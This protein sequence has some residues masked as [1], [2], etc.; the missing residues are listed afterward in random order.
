M[1]PDLGVEG[2]PVG[3]RD[4]RRIADD[5]VEEPGL[6]GLLEPREQVGV[7][8]ANPRGDMMLFGV[9]AGDLQG[10]DG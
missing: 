8:K 6:A 5:G 4:V 7:Q 1:V 2:E 10:G 3:L 9:G